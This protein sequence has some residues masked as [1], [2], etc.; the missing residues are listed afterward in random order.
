MDSQNQITTDVQRQQDRKRK[1]KALLAGG[2]VLGLGA[3]ATL[4]AWSDDVFADGVFNTGTFNIESSANGTVWDEHE[5]EGSAAP[6][7]FELTATQMAPD[8]TVYAPFSIRTDDDT[9]LDGEVALTGT[10]AD[11][12]YAGLLTYQ[13]FEVEAH[14]ENCN[15]ED[16]AELANEWAESTLANAATAPDTDPIA[17]AANAADEANLCIAVTLADQEAVEDAEDN[18]EPTSVIWEFNGQST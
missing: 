14:G 10:I 6:L 3:A 12:A 13:I 8:Q 4:A 5:T 18:T 7:S 2:V 16:S 15:P 1:R 11:G 9:S 17:I